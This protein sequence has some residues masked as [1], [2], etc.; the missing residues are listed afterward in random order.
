MSL[1]RHEADV[2]VRARPMPSAFV[3]RVYQVRRFGPGAKS[4]RDEPGR[5]SR[6]LQSSRRRRQRRPPSSPPASCAASPHRALDLTALVALR[7][8]GRSRRFAARWLQRWLD[9][10]PAATIDEAAMVVGCLATL[11]GP[12]HNDALSGPEPWR[13]RLPQ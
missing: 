10:P 13:W 4:T 3:S 9:E 1:E 8:R 11:G 6:D 2:E 7:D 12:A 5:P